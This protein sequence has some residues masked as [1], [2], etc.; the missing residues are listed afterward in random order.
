MGWPPSYQACVVFSKGSFL[1]AHSTSLSCA[2]QMGQPMN[3]SDGPVGQ[4]P[5]AASGASCITHGQNLAGSSEVP[6]L[7]IRPPALQTRQG[8]GA[9]DPG[10]NVVPRC[11]RHGFRFALNLN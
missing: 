3:T 11:C 1:C 10:V 6:W 4:T 5:E 8:L 2:A 9:A 7:P